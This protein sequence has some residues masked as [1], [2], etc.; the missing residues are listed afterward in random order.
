MTIYSTA[1]GYIQSA[2]LI[3]SNPLRFQVPNDAPFYL[4]YSMLSGFA[5]ELYLKAYLLHSGVNE[6]D[7]K[8]PPYGHNVPELARTAQERGLRVEALLSLVSLLGEGHKN[9]DFRYTALGT[10]Y[11][12][13]RLD[14][15]FASFG[16]LDAAVDSAVGASA[17]FGKAPGPGWSF[18]S[19]GALWRV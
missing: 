15:T 2:Y 19:N 13:E 10:R 17:F 5:L 18:P 14:L 1:R 12:A 6:V 4:S 7:L 3:M 9:L 11:S 16:K 8:K